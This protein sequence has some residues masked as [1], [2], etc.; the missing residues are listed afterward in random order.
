MLTPLT[1]HQKRLI[2]N[3]VVRACRNI[4]ALNNTGYRFIYLAQGFIAHYNLNGFKAHYGNGEDLRHDILRNAAPNMW[5]N[6]LPGDKD[7]EY[8]Q[9]KAD[10]Y[11]MICGMLDP[12]PN[13]GWPE[14]KLF[15]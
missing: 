15:G 1:Q 9:S 6:F 3:N 4:E 14:D 8:Y 10:A 7:Y 12:R 2:A 13:G 5:R 11:R